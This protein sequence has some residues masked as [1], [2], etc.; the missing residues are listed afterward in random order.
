[1]TWL[2][3]LTVRSGVIVDAMDIVRDR[4]EASLGGRGWWAY[5]SATLAGIESNL[6]GGVIC[7]WPDWGRRCGMCLPLFIMLVLAACEVMDMALS[8]VDLSGT[9]RPDG[10]IVEGP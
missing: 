1:M 8:L 4:I 10:V 7:S 2:C 9:V 5:A 6:G 3:M